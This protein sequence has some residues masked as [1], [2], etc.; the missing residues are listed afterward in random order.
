MRKNIN[1][2]IYNHKS[3]C[4]YKGVPRDRATS[5]TTKI[6]TNNSNNQHLDN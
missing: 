1:K 2:T 5:P 6:A 4:Y 3:I